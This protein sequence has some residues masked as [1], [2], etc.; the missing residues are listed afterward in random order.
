[1]IGAHEEV[2]TKDDYDRLSRWLA[3]SRK[4]FRY[5]LPRSATLSLQEEPG[6]TQKLLRRWLSERAPLESAER[7]RSY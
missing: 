2:T 7:G 4:H 3:L 5:E 1:M 6:K